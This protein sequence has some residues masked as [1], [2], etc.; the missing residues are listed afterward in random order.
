MSLVLE[1]HNDCTELTSSS[2]RIQVN[3]NA[4]YEVDNIEL[5][6]S[7]VTDNTTTYA[8]ND[9]NERTG[10]GWFDGSALGVCVIPAQAG[11]QRL[12]SSGDHGRTEK[13]DPM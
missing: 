9:A 10:R 7:S 6:G 4:D 13:V 5:I 1:E 12:N 11:I 2:F 8:Y 3:S